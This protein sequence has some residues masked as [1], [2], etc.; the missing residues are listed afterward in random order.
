MKN[1][2]LINEKKDFR[3]LQWDRV[4][5]SSGTAGSF[6]K[7][8]E[9]KAD[10]KIYYKLS[11]YDSVHGIVGHECVNELIVSR[12]LDIL[13]IPHVQYT[14][15][16]AMVS[17]DGREY[18]T[19]ICGSD[20]FIKK[21]E[22]KITWEDYYQFNK[23][24]NDN[25]IEFAKRMGF[26]KEIYRMILVDFL[27]LNRDRHGANIEM[28]MDKSMHVRMAPLFDHG[29]SLLFNCSNQDEI[30]KYD[31]MADKPVQ[32]FLGNISVKE[33]LH[34]LP[35]GFMVTDKF[36]CEH[37]KKYIL[38]DLNGIISTEHIDKIWDMIWRRWRYYESLR[39]I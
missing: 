5:S 4:R 1:G 19:Y 14:L 37:D 26:E 33:N 20:T 27:I 28:I 23:I 9:F 34:L 24:D 31:V 11:N 17:I 35:S 15:Y 3:Y 38:S 30:L 10:R 13:N 29:V 7:A 36:L 8:T 39:D 32:S 2:D 22:R 6:L 25:P 18:N 16:N 21:S 12:L